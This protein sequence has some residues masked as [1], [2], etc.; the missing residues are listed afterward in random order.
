LRPEHEKIERGNT[1]NYSIENLDVYRKSVVTGAR[2]CRSAAEAAE[3]GSP[4]LGGRLQEMALAIV[5]HLVDGLGFWEREIKVEHFSASKRAVLEILPLT[6][7][8][9]GM[10][11]MTADV[12]A[13][14]AAELRD[15]AKMISGLLRGAKGREKPAAADGSATAAVREEGTV[16]H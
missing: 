12:Q 8:M 7:I 15:L 1:V 2:L 16:Y 9:A 4:F 11:L 10:G 5:T 14:L 6:E 13:G 3:K